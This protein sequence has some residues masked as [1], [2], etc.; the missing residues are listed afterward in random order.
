MKF[1][2]WLKLQNSASHFITDRL[3]MHHDSHSWVQW[4]QKNLRRIK[5]P[6]V[7]CLGKKWARTVAARGR[8]PCET[9][10][11]RIHGDLFEGGQPWA[12]PTSPARDWTGW[13]A[14]RAPPAPRPD[15]FAVTHQ[16]WG[17]A[18][19][20]ASWSPQPGRDG[21]RLGQGHLQLVWEQSWRLS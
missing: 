11:P 13:G 16:V 19:K 7:W 18:G 5:V 17:P 9:L 8:E 15:V 14:A 1:Q 4:T 6:F 2:A 12:H 3:Q 10:S 21:T 20:S